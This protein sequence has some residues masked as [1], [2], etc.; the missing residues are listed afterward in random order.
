MRHGTELDFHQLRVEAERAVKESSLS[1]TEIGRKLG[2][3][4]SAMS[5]A[6]SETGS[7][8]SNL[9]R[10]IVEYLTGYQ[11]ERQVRFKVRKP[12]SD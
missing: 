6:L 5:R 4:R 1:Q 3:S 12:D 10:Q 2:V 9:Q 11:V 8:F 7:K